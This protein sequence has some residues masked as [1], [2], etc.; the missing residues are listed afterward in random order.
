MNHQ[1]LRV[2]GSIMG[3]NIQYII[4]NSSRGGYITKIIVTLCCVSLVNRVAGE[5]HKGGKGGKGC[6]QTGV[7]ADFIGVKIQSLALDMTKQNQ[8]YCQK[9]LIYKEKYVALPSI[10]CNILPKALKSTQ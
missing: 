9:A 10:R 4:L 6:F 5:D 7:H 1:T 2:G 8:K 3:V